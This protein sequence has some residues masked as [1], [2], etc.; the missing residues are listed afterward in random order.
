MSSYFIL[1]DL[2][3]V[4]FVFPLMHC[5]KFQFSL[6]MVFTD[7]DHTGLKISFEWLVQINLNF[8][9]MFIDL[10]AVI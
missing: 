1:L 6:N 7:I 8:Q 2:F 5:Y 9:R 10:R 3:E 4:V